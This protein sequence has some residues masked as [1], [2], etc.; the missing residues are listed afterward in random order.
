MRAQGASAYGNLWTGDTASVVFE[1]RGRQLRFDLPLPQRP[2]F[3][4]QETFER[5]G[6]RRWRCLLLAIKAKF[7]AVNSGISIFD[8]EFLANIVIPGT[9]NTVAERVTPAIA[10]A[11]ENPNIRLPPLLGMGSPP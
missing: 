8:T 2:K 1:A 9:S 3:S 4:N 7:E 11:Y 6:R 5:E 10:S